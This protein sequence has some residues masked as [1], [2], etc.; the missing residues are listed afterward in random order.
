MLGFSAGRFRLRDST[1]DV[2][3]LSADGLEV[4]YGLP[5]LQVSLG[6]AYT[7]LLLKPVAGLSLSAADAA[8]AADERRGAGPE[9]AA[10][11][12]G[13]AVCRSSSPCRP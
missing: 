11:P 13:A 8:D 6:A 5:A 7:G 2:L 4:S 1:G 3:S 12:G 10:G 9:A